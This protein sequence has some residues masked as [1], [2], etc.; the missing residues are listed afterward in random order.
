MVRQVPRANQHAHRLVFTARETARVSKLSA[1][2]RALK[3][4]E[5]GIAAET[6]TR[7]ETLGAGSESVASR[8]RR[9]VQRLR[10]VDT[11]TDE[12]RQRVRRMWRDERRLADTV[13]EALAVY[14]LMRRTMEEEET[15]EAPLHPLAV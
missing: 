12:M 5:M 15:Q 7:L 14:A 9:I 6:A 10:P 11:V 4:E 3:N 13:Q 1:E 8:T 2:L